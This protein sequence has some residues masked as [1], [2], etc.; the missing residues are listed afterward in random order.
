MN[1]KKLIAFTLIAVGGY[2][3]YRH[4]TGGKGKP[5][6]PGDNTT[7]DSIKMA[8]SGG[9]KPSV[10][11]YFPLKKGS[12]GQKVTELQQAILAVSPNSLPKYGADGDYGSETESA[13][14]A[15]LGKNSID[16]QDDIVKIL[17]VK[18]TKEAADKLATQKASRKALAQ[19][20]VNILLQKKNAPFFVVALHETAGQTGRFTSDG[21]KVSDGTKVWKK[22]YVVLSNTGNVTFNIDDSG[23]ITAVGNGGVFSYFSPYAVEVK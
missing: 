21:R 10:T 7:D 19:K 22:G 11:E 23:F 5:K 15:L 18:L 14:K 13:V 4:F 9:V 16:S 12:T 3:V 1:T 20:I 2:F 6:L 8:V 17:S